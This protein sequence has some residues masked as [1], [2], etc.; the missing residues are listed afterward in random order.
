MLLDPWMAASLIAK[1]FLYLSV[2]GAAGLSFFKV[3][4]PQNSDLI[5]GKTIIILATGGILAAIM[6]Y[7]LRGAALTGDM[8]GLY[9]LEMLGVL[10]E[11]HVGSAFL[12]RIVG[13]LLIL[14]GCILMNYGAVI[15]ALG[16]VITLWS[17]TRIGHV[18]D[19]ETIYASTLLLLHLCV[20]A[21]WIGAL[22]PIYQSIKGTLSLDIA[23]SLAERFGLIASILVPILIIAGVILSW[24]LVGSWGVLFTSIYGRVLIL[25]I[26]IV[27]V[28]LAL[29]AVNKLRFVPSLL[30]GS[31]KAAKHLGLSIKFEVICVVGV[32]CVTAILTSTVELPL[33][34]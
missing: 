32:L 9:D 24:L 17:F 20:A 4:F 6:G 11:T 21:F 23:A 30:N 16:A 28:L 1:I 19:V 14:V 31:Q 8:T 3:V 7:L 15:A 26:S 5:A 25:K 34:H 2:M 18:T 13:L 12:Y 33:S 22:Y 27:A 29:A 10:W